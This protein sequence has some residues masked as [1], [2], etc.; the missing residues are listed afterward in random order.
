MTI[1]TSEER[2]P[3]AQFYKTFCKNLHFLGDM[4]IVKYPRALP[5]KPNIINFLRP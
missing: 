2:K 3:R 1:K 5:A 4:Q